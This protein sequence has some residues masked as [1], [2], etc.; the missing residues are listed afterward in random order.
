MTFDD[1][2]KNM[3]LKFT[4]GNAIPVERTT[5]TREEWELIKAELNRLDEIEFMY[6]IFHR[7]WEG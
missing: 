6:N 2:Y 5:I 1:M 4:S 7:L 3:E